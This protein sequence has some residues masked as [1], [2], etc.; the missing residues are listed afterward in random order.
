MVRKIQLHPQSFQ[1][2]QDSIWQDPYI[3][4]QMLQ[5]HLDPDREGASRNHE[6]IQESVAWLTRHFPVENFAQVLDLGC[7][8]G[9]YTSPLARFGYQVSGIDF[10]KISIDY[11][12]LQFTEGQRVISHLLGNDTL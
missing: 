4:R 6:F 7:G 9:L 11:A 5:Q 8:P 12:H 2:G 1:Q 3:A 10:S